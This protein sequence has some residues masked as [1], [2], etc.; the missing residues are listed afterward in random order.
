MSIP[1][2]TCARCNYTSKNKTCMRRHFAKTKLCPA[3]SLDTDIELT[4]EIK[5]KILTNRIY[6]P[7]PKI[8]IK[9]KTVSNNTE[10]HYIYLLR[11]QEHISQNINV[12][13]IGRTVVKNVNVKVSRL[14]AYGKGSQTLMLK[15]C[16]NSVYC[17]KEILKIFNEK[18]EKYKFGSEYFIGNAD[19]MSEIIW[20]FIKLE[21]YE[22][23][24]NE[25]KDL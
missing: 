4:D 2:Y 22:N 19:E 20:D 18:F 10:L 7:P 1:Q 9:P 21:K 14:D 13:K 23:M 17:E 6:H 12:Y 8:I 3:K 16:I 5:E 25:N 15:T 24:K 11:A